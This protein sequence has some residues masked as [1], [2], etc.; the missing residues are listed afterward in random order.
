M[1]RWPELEAEATDFRGRGGGGRVHRWRPALSPF[2]RFYHG[3]AG[4][5]PALRGGAVTAPVRTASPLR[6]T[7]KRNTATLFLGRPS[8]RRLAGVRAAYLP[9]AA[10]N[11]R[12]PPRTPPAPCHRTVVA[13][14]RRP[15]P[16]LDRIWRPRPGRVTRGGRPSLPRTC[17]PPRHGVERPRSGHVR[18]RPPTPS[19]P[20]GSA[21]WASL[22][23][24]PSGHPQGGPAHDPDHRHLR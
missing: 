9:T 21:P 8:I 15:P 6:M 19:S 2:M 20:A 14:R 3:Q 4:E 24:E 12:H 7:S 10:L 17:V 13:T 22:L 11:R 16:A 5:S 23:R 18:T 1:P